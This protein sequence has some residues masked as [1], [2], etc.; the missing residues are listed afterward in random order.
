MSRN[1]NSDERKQQLATTIQPPRLPMPQQL[2]ERHGLTPSVWKVLLDS[3]WPGA[4]SVDGVALAL[5]Y[6]KAR[7]LDPFKR[8]VHIVPIYN[9]ALGRTVESVWPGISEIRTTAMRTGNYAGT[10]E[11]VFGPPMTQSFHD[12]QT[13]GRGDRATVVED[14]CGEITFPSWGQMTVYRMVQ[15]QRVPFVGPKV[16]WLETYGQSKGLDVPNSMWRRR[17][18]GQLEKCVEAAALRKAFPEELGDVYAAEEVEGQAFRHNGGPAIDGGEIEANN[19]GGETEQGESPAERRKREE[20]EQIEAY[21]ENL[22]RMVNDTV[23][24][25]GLDAG[26]KSESRNWGTFSDEQMRRCEKLFNDRRKV[27]QAEAQQQDDHGDQDGDQQQDEGQEDPKARAYVDRL[28]E[29]LSSIEKQ[30]DLDEFLAFER[31]TFEILSP[32][33]RAI[34]ESH[35]E[36]CKAAMIADQDREDED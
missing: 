28:P 30:A 26:Q 12:R 18:Y 27:L 4:T 15:G 13:R 10:D 32:A 19:Q 21:I 7:N 8:P 3:V 24:I 20:Q 25:S 11:I 35:V 1:N 9:S 23:K 34:A 6:C 14:Q 36:D 17:T 29:R 16:F 22:A 5:D 2:A 33:L 31:E